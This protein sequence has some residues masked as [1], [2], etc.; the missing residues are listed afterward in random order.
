MLWQFGELGYDYSINTCSDGVTINNNC[1]LD[2][3]PIRWDYLQQANRK[4]LHDVFRALIRL[5]FNPLY[6]DMF[7]SNSITKDFAND[8][9]WLQVVSGS[10]KMVVMGNFNVIDQTANITFPNAGTWYDYLNGNTIIATGASQPFT[11]Q[12]GEYHV[13]LNQNATLPVTLINFNGKNNG[14]SNLL[15]WTVANEQNINTYE[16]QRSTDGQ[17]FSSVRSIAA[18]GSS[19]YNYSDDITR[20]VSPVYY[21]RLKIINRDGG[22]SYSA[23]VKIRMSVNEWVVQVNPNPFTENIKLNIESPVQDKA[24]IILTDVSGRQL[25]KQN[26]SISAGN[27]AFE[28]NEASQLS[29]GTYVLTI[30]SSQQTQ[31]IKVI[32][33]N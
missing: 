32:K 6:T 27:N 7:L 12:A 13:Y 5:R 10:A 15:T 16:L 18:A 19:A 28:L 26:I 24:T 21:Y 14:S 23:I 33:G 22:L 30:V 1:R 9:K 31:N 29:K 8:V 25:I 11:L 20:A 2:Q 17:N 4:Q 3:K